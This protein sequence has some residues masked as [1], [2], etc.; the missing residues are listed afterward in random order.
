[1]MLNLTSYIFAM[2]T[3]SY[4][5]DRACV[6]LEASGFTAMKDGTAQMAAVFMKQSSGTYASV[7]IAASEISIAFS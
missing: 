5:F 1:M 6:V 7:G 4:C 3:G 2:A